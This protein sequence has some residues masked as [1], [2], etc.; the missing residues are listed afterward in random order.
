MD[1]QNQTLLRAACRNNNHGVIQALASGANPNWVSDGVAAIHPAAAYGNTKMLKALI[2]AGADL[3]LPGPDGFTALHE[4]CNKEDLECTKLL[5]E[6][7]ADLSV[8][9]NKDE[10]PIMVAAHARYIAPARYTAYKLIHLL[11]QHGAQLDEKNRNGFAP[12]HQACQGDNWAAALGL[13]DCGADVNSTLGTTNVTALHL[14]EPRKYPV[15]VKAL[16]AAGADPNIKT[17][18]RYAPL[19]NACCYKAEEAA[20]ALLDAGAEL[21]LEDEHGPLETACYRGMINVVEK[22]IA[23]AQTKRPFERLSAIDLIMARREG[24]APGRVIIEAQN[25]W[26]CAA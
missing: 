11:S 23:I 13:I 16:L 18:T 3:N 1:Y 8:K 10:T 21:E 22:F 5:L 9:S 25:Q 14:L 20:L 17:P 24:K 12:L 15:L 4:T 6:A 2:E 7:G 19:M 26:A